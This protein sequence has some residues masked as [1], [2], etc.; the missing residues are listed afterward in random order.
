[1]QAEAHGRTLTMRRG[2]ATLIA[3]FDARTVELRA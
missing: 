1:V 2:D 3:D